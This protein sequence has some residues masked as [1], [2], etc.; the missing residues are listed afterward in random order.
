[1][2]RSHIYLIPFDSPEQC[3]RVINVIALHNAEHGHTADYVRYGLDDPYEQLSVGA[4]L[5]PA[6]TVNFKPGKMFASP[7]EGP[8]LKSAILVRQVG[9]RA[10]TATYLRWHL[11]RMLP[12]VYVAGGHAI[13][14]Y[15]CSDATRKRLAWNT[16]E[17]I[18]NK[19]MGFKLADVVPK[20]ARAAPCARPAKWTTRFCVPNPSYAALL[21]GLTPEE[22][23][24]VVLEERSV[25][26][27]ITAYSTVTDG[28]VV[29]DRQFKDQQCAESHVWTVGC[30]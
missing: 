24:Q 6:V 9:D 26:P 20:D 4:P 29:G 14:C 7:D 15:V 12:D 11:M 30:V 23:K 25:L 27:Y 3:E 21:N 13:D 17:R 22:R 8:S 16:E 19:R 1:M 18:P 10:A 2:Q 28:Y 5:G